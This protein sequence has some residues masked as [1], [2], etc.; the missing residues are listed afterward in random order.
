MGLI[1]N[2]MSFYLIMNILSFWIDI[3]ETMIT[4]QL[5]KA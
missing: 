2:N 4:Y 3:D 1:N 5:F